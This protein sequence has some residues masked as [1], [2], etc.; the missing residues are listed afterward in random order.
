MQMQ[1]D[2]L[3]AGML[4]HAALFLDILYAWMRGCSHGL[5]AACSLACAWAAML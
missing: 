2:A 1:I 3:G 5:A 4:L